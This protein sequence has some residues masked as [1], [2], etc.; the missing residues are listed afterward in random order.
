M[1]DRGHCGPYLRLCPHR[2]PHQPPGRPQLTSFMP[3]TMP[4]RCGPGAAVTWAVCSTS[5]TTRTRQPPSF[6]WPIYAAHSRAGHLKR[7]LDIEPR[8]M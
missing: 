3:R 7:V 8:L 1:Q 4:R 5:K 6:D 2:V